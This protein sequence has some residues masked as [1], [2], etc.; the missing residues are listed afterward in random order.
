MFGKTKS[1]NITSNRVSPMLQCYDSRNRK[2]YPKSYH[3]IIHLQF[4]P[5]AKCTHISSLPIIMKHSHAF[6]T[7]CLQNKDMTSADFFSRLKQLAATVD[8]QVNSSKAEFERTDRQFCYPVVMKK[9]N[10]VQQETKDSLV[11]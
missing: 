5:L 8:R 9:I 7:F 3:W 11:K 6:T 4:C 10:D 1:W 2:G